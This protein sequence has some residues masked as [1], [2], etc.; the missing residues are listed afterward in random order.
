MSE[1][2]PTLEP[3]I[4]DK[5]YKITPM[6]PYVEASNPEI[7]PKAP[8]FTADI[9]TALSSLKRVLK[10]ACTAWREKDDDCL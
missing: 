1:Q 3:L 8:N 5:L 4:A 9:I 6:K 10:D 2:D 7:E